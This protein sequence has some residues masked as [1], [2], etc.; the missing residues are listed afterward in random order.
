MNLTA[1]QIF[2]E[3]VREESFSRGAR[4]CGI[5][6][7][8]ASQAIAQ[9][10]GELDVLLIDRSRRPFALTPEGTRFFEGAKEILETLG[11]LKAEVQSSR[12]R[13][14]GT[15]RVAAIYSIGI[16]ALSRI[17]QQFMARFPQTR[18]RTEY[19][20]PDKV[21][22][23]VVGG[24]ADFGLLSYI[25]PNRS[26]KVVPLRLET[27]VLVAPPSH[28]LM[29]GGT[30]ALSDLHGLDFVA[31]DHDL[32]IRKAIDRRLAREKVRPNI[33]MEFDNIETIKQA[34]EI[35]VGVSIL[36]RPTV[37]REVAQG[38][39]HEMVLPGLDL[40]RPI[41]IIHGRNKRLTPAMI[42]FM[43]S[44]KETQGGYEG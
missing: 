42:K 27:M 10:E 8:A 2:C 31:F 19:L 22:E 38:Q 29:R 9:L 23:V 6:Q 26:L 17:I 30:V 20:R 44:L 25:C 15:I 1:L 41:V 11:K 21:M 28:P 33:V 3:I 24:H 12:S 36:P 43:E 16:Q 13:M 4:V 18:V 40:T 34:L 14:S 7:P 32:A 35:G 5:T 39:L 37:L